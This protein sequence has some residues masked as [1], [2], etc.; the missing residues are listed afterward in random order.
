M[1]KITEISNENIQ[2]IR[3]KIA[4]D[5]IP[6]KDII[7]TNVFKKEEVTALLRQKNTIGVRP[8]KINGRL[9]L[10]A[11][12]ETV[13]GDNGS[14]YNLMHQAGDLLAESKTIQHESTDPIS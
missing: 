11:I 9:Y 1:K 10:I 6:D 8:V 7:R 4:L 12:R 13:T 14:E 5:S 2:I 3:S